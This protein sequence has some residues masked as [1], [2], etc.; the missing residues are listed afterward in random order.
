MD[1]AFHPV[2]FLLNRVVTE[3]LRAAPPGSTQTVVCLL[4]EDRCNL[5]AIHSRF[6]QCPSEF[7]SRIFVG[8]LCHPLFKESIQGCISVLFSYLIW[9]VFIILQ[10]RRMSVC[11]AW[12]YRRQLHYFITAFYV[13]QQL[14][15]IFLK[16]FVSAR[17]FPAIPILL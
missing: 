3:P 14:F 11:R 15:L 5:S 9:K 7:S 13:C 8:G 10:G 4:S 16:N 12:F 1:L 17:F 2:S 6:V